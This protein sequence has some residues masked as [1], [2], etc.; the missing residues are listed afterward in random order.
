VSGEAHSQSRDD[1]PRPVAYSLDVPVDRDAAPPPVRRTPRRWLWVGAPVGLAAIAAAVLLA[2]LGTHGERSSTAAH[3]APR[4]TTPSHPALSPVAAVPTAPTAPS[5]PAPVPPAT[6][7]PTIASPLPSVAASPGTVSP[8]PAPV[9]AVE[10][11]PGRHHRR[12]AHDAS[13]ATTTAPAAHPPT[14]PAVVVGRSG[15][16]S[17][18][19]F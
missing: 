18:D 7:P 9:V 3:G 19:D 5:P 6:P 11:A 16:I 15:T 13:G 17:A 4:T 12:G 1:T 2:V 8:V 10:V 14:G